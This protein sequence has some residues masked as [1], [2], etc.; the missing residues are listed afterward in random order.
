MWVTGGSWSSYTA[1]GKVA[2]PVWHLCSVFHIAMCGVM[3]S[4]SLCR[5]WLLCKRCRVWKLL[6][7]DCY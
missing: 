5:T 3:E 1:L 2:G 6:S 4:N 7:G